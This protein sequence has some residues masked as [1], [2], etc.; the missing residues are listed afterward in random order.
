M[1]WFVVFVNHGVG[2]DRRLAVE[3][4]FVQAPGVTG[5]ERVG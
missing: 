2:V 3:G 4:E 5:G 1:C